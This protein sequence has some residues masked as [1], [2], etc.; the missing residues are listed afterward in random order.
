MRLMV[1]RGLGR[2]SQSGRRGRS[3]RG[4]LAIGL[5]FH[6]FCDRSAGGGIRVPTRPWRQVDT[7]MLLQVILT[8]A[9]GLAAGERALVIPLAGMDSQMPRQVS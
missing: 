7:I 6:G 9:S 4:V 3:G 5:C 1:T 8:R 2:K